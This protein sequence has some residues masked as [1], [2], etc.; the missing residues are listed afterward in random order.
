MLYDTPWLPKEWSLDDV[1]MDPGDPTRLYRKHIF[2][3]SSGKAKSTDHHPDRVDVVDNESLFCLAVALLELTFGAPLS[4][5]YD[6]AASQQIGEKLAKLITAKR[7]TRLIRQHE[8]ERFASVIIKCMNPPSSSPTEYDFSFENE[9]F[10][11]QFIKD[12]LMPLYQDVILLQDS[13]AARILW[14]GGD[15]GDGNRWIRL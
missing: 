15:D 6:G 2:T 7:L 11:R 14:Q 8:Q 4:N 9:S 5:F 3:R 12:V 10:R 1:Y 13:G